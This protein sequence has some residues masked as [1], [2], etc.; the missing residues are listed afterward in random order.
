MVLGVILCAKSNIAIADE[1]R[2][3]IDTKEGIDE[4]KTTAVVDI[5]NHEIRL[6]KFMPNMA[7]FL[8]DGLEY[9]VLTP[10]GIQRVNADGSMTIIVSTASLENPIAGIAGSSNY[11]DF[12]V[13]HGPQITHYSFAGEYIPNPVLS[14]QGYTNIMSV[15]T[16][17]LDY[18]VLTDSEASYQA[19]T[20]SEMISAGPLSP[21]GFSNPIAMTLFKD[22]YGMAV[23]DGEQVKYYKNGSLTHTI[24]GLTN[25]LSV[26]AADGGNLAIVADNKIKHY[27]LLGDDTFAEN[28]ILSITS[29]LTSPTCVAL[30]PDSYDRLIIDGNDIKYYMWDGSGLLLN[31]TMSKTIE[32][33]QDIGQFLPQAIAESIAYSV[34]RDVTHIKLFIDPALQEQDLDTSIEWYVAAQDDAWIKVNKLGEWVS[35]EEKTGSYIRWKAVLKTTNR[36]H[37]PIINP[38]IVVQSNSKPNPPILELPPLSG[39][40]RCY[41]NSSPVIRWQFSDPD[42]GDTQGGMQVKIYANGSVIEDSGFIHGETSEYMVDAG[43]SGKIYESGTNLFTAEV[44]TYDAAGVV[45]DPSS[46]Q[47]CVIAFDRP[48]TEIIT[49]PS[50]GFIPKGGALLLGTKAG[51]L[52]TLRVF[53]I[54]VDTVQFKFPYLTQESTLVGEPKKIESNGSNHRWEISFFTD[55]NIDICPEGT[56]VNGYFTGN[57]TPNLMFLDDRVPSEEPT[58]NWWQWEGYRKWADG[59][60]RVGES[61]F[62]NWSVILQG[63]KRK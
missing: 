26:S 60:V 28:S 63:S 20:G 32:G 61:V 38:D 53:G 21:S 42:P 11:P 7:D 47:F 39:P 62:Q 22:H 49:P 12:V 45:S 24:T 9:I 8:G 16:R 40:D 18:A 56:I 58:D 19:F 25:A 36:Q 6:P 2:Y 3:K 52:V 34:G 57:G 35:L 43:S 30:R 14:S 1:F 23:L 41:L 51:G 46:K 44:L 13:A 55:A 4:A 29:G 33:L 31:P 37:T 15:S 17:D 48:F 27:N 50:S 59:V 5:N 54:G 10:D